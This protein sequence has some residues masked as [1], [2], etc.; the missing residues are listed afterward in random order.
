MRTAVL[1]AALALVACCRP[2]GRGQGAGQQKILS[3]GLA[4]TIAEAALADARPRAS[5]PRS[6]WLIAPAQL[7]VLLRDEAASA[8]MAK[9]ARRK[10]YTARMS[11]TSTMEFQKRTA[12]PASGAARRR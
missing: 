5:P 10:A 3:L 6:P 1:A 2:G 12:D 11:R 8:Q 9:M 4:K 7:L